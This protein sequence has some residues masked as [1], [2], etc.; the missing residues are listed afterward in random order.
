MTFDQNQA[1]PSSGD[2]FAIRAVWFSREEWKSSRQAAKGA[3]ED[4][5]EEREKTRRLFFFLCVCLGAL[6][7]LA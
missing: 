5:K 2:L 7:G 1:G 4:A 3:K 6:G